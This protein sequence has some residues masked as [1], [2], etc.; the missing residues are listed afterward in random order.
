MP[1]CV[2]SIAIFGV[3]TLFRGDFPQK[4]LVGTGIKKLNKV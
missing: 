3:M 1:L 2:R 4:V